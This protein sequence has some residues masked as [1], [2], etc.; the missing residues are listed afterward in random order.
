MVTRGW[1]TKKVTQD[2]FASF[3][4]IPKAPRFFQRAEG[5]PVNPE[6]K[7]LAKDWQNLYKPERT[8]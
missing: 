1:K 4:V 2:D 5:S 3:G 8:V 6:W 7:D